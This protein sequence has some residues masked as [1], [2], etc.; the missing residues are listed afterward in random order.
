ME[1]LSEKDQYLIVNYSDREK[2]NA[3]ASDYSVSS[4]TLRVK[5]Y[6]IRQKLKA[7]ITQR[8]NEEVRR[9]DS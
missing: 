5:V 3:L 4:E 7:R 6:R 9:A 1:K 8:L 2:R